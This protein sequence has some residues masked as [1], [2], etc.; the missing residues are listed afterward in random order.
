MT[1]G[2]GRALIRGHYHERV[3]ATQPIAYWPLWEAAG[4]VAQ[5]LVNPAQNGTYNSDVSAWPVGTG[6]GDGNTAPGFDGVNDYVDILTAP[7]VAAFNGDEGT[8]HQWIRVDAAGTWTDGIRRVAWYCPVDGN[9]WAL[10]DKSNANNQFRYFYSAGAVAESVIR[11]SNETGWHTIAMTWSK[12]ADEFR[13]YWDGVQTGATQTVLGNW[14]GDLVEAWI[15]ALSGV[16]AS[17][18]HGQIAH[19]VVWDR[20]LPV[21]TI[22][23]LAIA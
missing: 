9:N 3:L 12:A 14:A 15:G 22:A 18:W 2:T 21:S 10:L 17:A 1:V 8:V 19:S 5:C 4:T 6:I 13:A 23:N 11:A 16:P 20:A 7:Y